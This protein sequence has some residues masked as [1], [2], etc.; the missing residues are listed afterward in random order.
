MQTRYD[1]HE[2]WLVIRGDVSEPDEEID[3]NY[4]TPLLLCRGYHHYS[5]RT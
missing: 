5:G 4:L 2:I 3:E 1:L